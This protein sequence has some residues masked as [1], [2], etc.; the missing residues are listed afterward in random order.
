MELSGAAEESN[1]QIDICCC[2]HLSYRNLSARNNT[3]TASSV[4]RHNHASSA[5]VRR[6]YAHGQWSLRDDYGPPPSPQVPG[7][8]CG[9]RLPKVGLKTPPEERGV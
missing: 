5:C 6:G 9:A 2:L 4:G 7:V 3:R 8:G 1:D